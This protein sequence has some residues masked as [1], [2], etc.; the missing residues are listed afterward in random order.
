MMLMKFYLAYLISQAAQTREGESK[1]DSLSRAGLTIFW[2]PLFILIYGFICLIVSDC[3]LL[4]VL[5][6]SIKREKKRLLNLSSNSDSL[7]EELPNSSLKKK[8]IPKKSRIKKKDKLAKEEETNLFHLNT[9]GSE[10]MSQKRSEEG[11][12]I[13]PQLTKAGKLKR[14]K[15]I[16]P[17]VK[18][19]VVSIKSRKTQ[20]KKSK[21]STK[22]RR[23][24]HE[25]EES[26][27][28]RYER[29][30]NRQEFLAESSQKLKSYRSK[31]SKSKGRMS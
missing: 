15:F 16:N 14:P 2:I 10:E 25:S 22:R 17:Y 9:I 24:G 21:W 3:K 19:R 12:L 18:S 1:E 29:H 4:F 13:H 8:K 11:N 31:K 26:D 7:D 27:N 20:S 28:P 23:L 6:R 5:R 30:K